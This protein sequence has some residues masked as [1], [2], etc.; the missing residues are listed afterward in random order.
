M[1]IIYYPDGTEVTTPVNDFQ[2]A[3]RKTW[4]SSL[5]PGSPAAGPLNPVLFP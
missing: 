5:E 3:D 4:L 2:E 1:T